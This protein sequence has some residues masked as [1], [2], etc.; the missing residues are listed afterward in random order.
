MG[1]K[2]DVNTFNWQQTSKS[3]KGRCGGWWDNKAATGSI[4]GNKRD[5]PPSCI[6]L[7]KGMERST[8]IKSADSHPV[9][10][11]MRALH[12]HIIDSISARSGDY[13]PACQMILMLA[14]ANPKWQLWRK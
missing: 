14:N 3:T 7:L 10:C 11:S 2:F 6:R 9:R 12:K 8:K 13:A 4:S 1:R 5:G